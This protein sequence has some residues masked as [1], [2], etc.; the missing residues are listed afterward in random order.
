MA[1]VSAEGAPITPFCGGTKFKP[2]AQYDYFLRTS[3]RL[4]YIIPKA[5]LMHAQLEQYILIS[6]LW[7]KYST[8][9]T[10][11]FICIIL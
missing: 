9:V 11:K 6:E 8:Q 2:V 1:A 10:V 4:I 5:K 3:P 7:P